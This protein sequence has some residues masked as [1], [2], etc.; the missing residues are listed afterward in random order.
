MASYTDTSPATTPTEERLLR[1]SLCSLPELRLT[2]SLDHNIVP[3]CIVVEQP[4][5]AGHSFTPRCS[6]LALQPH[7]KTKSCMASPET[8]SCAAV[9]PQKIQSVVNHPGKN[10]R[11]VEA[12]TS[13]SSSP[14]VPYTR[15]RFSVW[16]QR[17]KLRGSTMK[18]RKSGSHAFSCRVGSWIVLVRRSALSPGHNTK[19]AR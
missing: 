9:Q 1:H 7:K 13:E 4:V 14:H 6:Q 3:H 15:D 5:H 2:S 8:C 10:Q 12:I 19:Q 16:G 11:T 18:M 17:V